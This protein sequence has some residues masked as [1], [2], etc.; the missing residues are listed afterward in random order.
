MVWTFSP[1]TSMLLERAHWVSLPTLGGAQEHNGWN[2]SVPLVQPW[3][4]CMYSHSPQGAPPLLLLLSLSCKRRTNTSVY[5]K[6]VNVPQFLSERGGSLLM[7]F[8]V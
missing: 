3:K 1:A 7:N 5:L 8:S 4:R 6:L 2:T